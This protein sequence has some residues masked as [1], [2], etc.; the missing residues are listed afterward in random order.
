ML[1]R[2]IIGT[3]AAMLV[4]I[5]CSLASRCSAQ[6]Y[7]TGGGDGDFENHGSAGQNSGG[8]N[9]MV[10]SW[11][12]RSAGA[13]GSTLVSFSQYAQ[14]GSLR[15]VSVV[16][17]GQTGNPTSGQRYQIWGHYTVRTLGAH[18]YAVTVRWDGYA[19][20]RSCIQGG[21]CQNMPVPPAGTETEVFS[22]PN[23][24]HS[25]AEING[26]SADV[27]IERSQIP[28]QLLTQVPETVTMAAPPQQQ[29]PI[30][31]SQSTPSY[32]PRYQ[33]PVTKIPGIGGNC[34]NAQ[35]DRICTIN[36]HVEYTDNRGCRVCTP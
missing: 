13:G 3:F 27:D 32:G 30:G 21:Q 35:Q 20:R 23:H 14:N 2:S 28:P 1:N 10:G 33:S 4:V 7:P 8:S 9:P 22:D 26:Q 36:G 29:Q 11:V 25:H 31:G 19:P 15:V 16:Q 17:G 5:A 34:D 6:S 18:R 12:S 24:F